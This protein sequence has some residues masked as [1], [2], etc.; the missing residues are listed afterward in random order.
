VIDVSWAVVQ[1]SQ[2]QLATPPRYLRSADV[3]LVGFLDGGDRS[4]ALPPS[5]MST[6]PAEKENP[7]LENTPTADPAKG[8][9]SFLVSTAV[10][11][12]LLINN[13]PLLL[14]SQPSELGPLLLPFGQIRKLDV[15]E[16]SGSDAT[17]GFITVAVEY[18]TADS[19]YE[20]KMTLDGQVYANHVIK[21]EFVQPVPS[22]CDTLAPQVSQF[23][24]VDDFSAL[25]A[26]RRPPLVN[27]P[28]SYISKSAGMTTPTNGF[29]A[30]GMGALG[31][32]SSSAP[33]TPYPFSAWPGMPSYL[34]S[35]TPLFDGRLDHAQPLTRFAEA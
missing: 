2:G 31:P 25:Q 14:F 4:A 15:V 7:P 6:P 16:T 19:A 13:L 12:S 20:A 18:A 29:L 1:R 27:G 10:T 24:L 5:I 26:A 32:T 34:A 33:T 30:A 9:Q 28:Y 22:A 17:T 35:N 11:S 8:T 21:I 23:P 3:S